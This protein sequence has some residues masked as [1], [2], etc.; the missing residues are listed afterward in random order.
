MTV[1]VI[2][3]TYNSEEYIRKSLT[4]VTE[5]T[6]SDLEILIIDDCS[7]DNTV[8]IVKEYAKNDERIKLITLEKN[9][10]QGFCRQKGIEEAKGEYITFLD[11]DDYYDREFVRKMYDKIT[12]DNADMTVC[13]FKTSDYQTGEITENHGY[14]NYTNV[15]E[16]LH[17]GFC[18]DD[19][20]PIAIFNTCNVIWDKIYKKSF[21]IEKDVRFPGGMYCEDDVFTIDAVLKADKISVLNLPLVYYTINRPNATSI[22]FESVKNDCFKMFDLVENNLKRAN[23]YQKF[24]IPFLKYK[25]FTAKYYYETVPAEFKEEFNQKYHEAMNRHKETLMTHF[26]KNFDDNV[27]YGELKVFYGIDN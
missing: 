15:P 21:L 5:Q 11:S 20:E 25:F 27:F 10:K 4:S 18:A 26:S 24:Q 6:F 13:K 14:R 17:N 16:E 19:L 22:V 1:S 9:C 2:I 8:N 7:C 3:P 23:L 12:Q